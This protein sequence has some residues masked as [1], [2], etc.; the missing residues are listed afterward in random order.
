[1]SRRPTHFAV[2]ISNEAHEASLEVR[3]IY[4][5]LPDPKAEG[6][7]YVRVI[8]ESGEDYLFPASCFEAIEVP[9]ALG[10]KLRRAS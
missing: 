4:Q 2:C 7:G 6:H 10:R 9:A 1:M 3:K 5:R 8:D